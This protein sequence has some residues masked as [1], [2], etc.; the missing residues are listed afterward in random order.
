MG[1][2]PIKPR[3]I[4]YIPFGKT[5]KSPATIIATGREDRSELDDLVRATCEKRGLNPDQVVEEAEKAYEDR[6]KVREASKELHARIR[7]Q[8]EYSKLRY[9]GLRPPV[10]RSQGGK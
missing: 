3:K 6:A 2:L 4:F 7:E 8:S 1:N 5:K 10:K 9:G